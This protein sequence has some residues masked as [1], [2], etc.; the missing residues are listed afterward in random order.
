MRTRMLA[1]VLSLSLFMMAPGLAEVLHAQG[2]IG[3]IKSLRVGLHSNKVRL[4]AVFDGF[5]K[6][7]PLYTPGKV[8]TLVF[9]GAMPSPSI[10][11]RLV[12]QSV[13]LKSHLKEITIRYR[14]QGQETVLT[15]AGEI[16]A[17]TPHSF[18]L[19]NPDR[20][21]V[22][23]PFSA[24]TQNKVSRSKKTSRTPAKPGQKVY[25]IPG[26]KLSDNLAD[27][28]ASLGRGV[29]PV[30]FADHL[31]RFRVIL[32]PGHGGKDCG[33]TSVY[34]I[35]EKELV[36]DISKRLAR[37]LQADSRFS[38]YLTRDRDVFIPLRDRTRIANRMKG[39]LFLSIHANSD[40][41][42]SVRGIE[43]FLLNL[44]SSDGRSKEV[45]SRENSEL[46][47]SHGDLGSILL[48]LR[49]NHKKKRSWEFAHDLDESIIR[50]LVGRY[51]GVRD[52][53]IRQAP[54]YVI[55]GTAMPAALTEINFLSNRQDARIMDNSAY[56]EQVSLALYQGIV[57]YYQRVHPEIQARNLVSSG[58][59]NP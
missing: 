48:T 59:S 12:A 6:D 57:R 45:A 49:V 5:P 31:T 14:K 53:G 58:I 2:K 8:G 51:D 13:S 41:N 43:T 42:P 40:P 21:V 24:G 30:Q 29:Q 26:K 55:M 9:K 18:T 23:F 32:D 16:S 10:Q 19:R 22:D 47:L 25:V 44:R 37:R 54:F 20:I 1:L 52:L 56:R 4:V 35:C 3:F 50:T 38:V 15:V 28:P 36:L 27:P 11:R 33:T 46:G 39:D 17:S 7:A 34:G